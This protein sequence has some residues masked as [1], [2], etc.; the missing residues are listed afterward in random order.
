[1]FVYLLSCLPVKQQKE[2]ICKGS[3]FEN[4]VLVCLSFLLGDKCYFTKS[5]GNYH[6]I[7]ECQG[8]EGRL[9]VHQVQS[10]CWSRNT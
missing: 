10:P 9:K 3:G 8:L 6:R 1:M 4:K 7:T 2:N 5:W